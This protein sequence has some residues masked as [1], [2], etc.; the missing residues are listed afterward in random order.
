MVVREWA[1]EVCCELGYSLQ[2]PVDRIRQRF[3]VACTLAF[4]IG[5][6]NDRD[7]VS[8]LPAYKSRLWP[9]SLS[10]EGNF[11]AQDF[12]GFIT[13]EAD[14]LLSFGSSY[15]RCVRWNTWIRVHLI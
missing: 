13:A 12:V 15:L 14:D 11:V 3:A 10:W 2:G 7:Y 5:E 1:Q 6:E 4:D 8:R 9:P